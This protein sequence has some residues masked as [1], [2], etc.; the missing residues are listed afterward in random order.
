MAYQLVDLLE[1]LFRRILIERILNIHEE[2]VIYYDALSLEY[3]QDMAMTYEQHYSDTEMNMKIFDFCIRIEQNAES[4]LNVFDVLADYVK[5]VLVFHNNHVV[6]RYDKILEWNQIMKAIGEELPVLA[7][8]VRHFDNERIIAGSFTWAPIISHNN[9]QLIKILDKGIA[10]NH[11]HLRVSAP[12]F[13]ISW[14]NLMN[15]PLHIINSEAFRKINKNYRDKNKRAEINILKLPL[16]NLVLKAA[17]IRFFLLLKIKKQSSELEKRIDVYSL[18]YCDERLEIQVPLIQG[19]L[20]SIPKDEKNLD[21]MLAFTT[22][23]YYS[24][25]EEYL[26]LSGERWFIYHMLRSV[27]DGDKHFTR[28]DF[29]LFYAYL[30]IKNELRCELVQTNDLV[31]FE[32]FQIYQSR[33]NYFTHMNNSATYEALLTRMAIKDVLVNPA[34]KSLE[35]RISP[36]STS[37]E[38]AE[39]IRL[40][41]ESVIRP[42]S[43]LEYFEHQIRDIVYPQKTIEIKEFEP[44]DLRKRFQYVFHFTKKRDEPMNIYGICECRHYQ[45]RKN[46]E[47]TAEQILAFRKDYPQ[48]GRRVV[49]ID[50][51][52]QELGCR[53]EVFGK[54]FRALKS[55]VYFDTTL[56]YNYSLPQLKVTYHVGEE[57]L[58]ITDGLRAITEAIRFLR[59][60][61]GD[62]LGHA[63][64]LGID[65]PKW[66]QFKNYQVTLTKQDYLDNIVWFHHMLIKYNIKDNSALK[67]WLESEYSRYFSEIY[68]QYIK[69]VNI[70]HKQDNNMDIID[71]FSNDYIRKRD[72]MN[73]VSLKQ[74][75]QGRFD[76]HTYYLAWRLRGDAPEL[77][78]TGELCEKHK[79]NLWEKY[80]IN[81]DRVEADDIRRIPEVALMYYMYHYNVNVRQKGSETKTFSIPLRYIQG[82]ICVQKAMREE[83]VRRGIAIEMN[84]SSNISISILS[85]YVDHP[86]KTLYNLG[87][88]YNEEELMNCPQMNVSINTDDKGLFLTRLENEY[89]LMARALENE[90]KEDG[91][92]KYK[93]EFI[94]QWLDNI[95]K[96][97]LRQTF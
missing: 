58:D 38:N 54:V 90:K 96:M 70:R 31:G 91:S 50:A 36:K 4:G 13:A 19:I 86:I 68:Q 2:K 51:C 81:T 63:L 30:R 25:E 41:D 44:S 42:Y 97:G 18:I 5:D 40:C 9:N 24:D 52:S 61:C 1:L 29:N 15:Y 48:Y 55:Y 85:E 89:A 95:R 43:D 3:I 93:K 72:F 56:P 73:D 82:L 59:L 77:Y 46:L 57:F 92:P 14:L 78:K 27:Y 62:R 11:F 83:I 65:I 53:P 75:F 28:Q 64:A 16:G 10:D 8:M 67:G 66:Y 60:D 94:Y 34:V 12:Y 7:V 79:F 17:L 88:T 21:Y 32:N 74:N 20:D 80:E 71:H 87:L 76:I 37:C 47:K 39:Y 35:V 23:R 33:K 69:E 26:I 22:N 49:G 84:P 45:Y 6:C